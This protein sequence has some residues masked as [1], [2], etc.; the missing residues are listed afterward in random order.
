MSEVTDLSAV[1]A[2][3]ALKTREV[4][5]LDL[6]DAVAERLEVVEPVANA[7]PIRCLDRAYARARRLMS[8]TERRSPN[9]PV[10]LAGLPVSVKDVVD[11][12]GVPTTYGSRAY[13]DNIAAVS[14]P[15]IERIEDRGA[16]VVGKTNTPEFCA[17]ADTVN[18]LFGRTAKPL[19]RH[20]DLWRVQRR[21]RYVG[22]D[23]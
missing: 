1:A 10:W 4:S 19:G 11:V 9:P 3:R 16:I 18:D 7:V 6:L 8:R 17:G 2:V 20:R 13:R 14:S 12:A 21:G 5:P 23:R 15:L 22:G